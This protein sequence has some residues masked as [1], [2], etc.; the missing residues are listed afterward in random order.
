MFFTTIQAYCLSKAGVEETFPF[1][2]TTVVWKVMG[3]MF[4]V[5]D[6]EEFNVIA[7]KCD[8]ER[9]IKLREEFDQIKPGYHMNKKLW[10]SV[11]LE[12]LSIEMVYELIDHSYDL[13]VAKLTKTLKT[14]LK[15]LEEI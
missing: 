13:V 10:N 6:I 9:S 15:E 3:K 4:C 14:Q 12:G 2:E 1:D 8:P 11:Y 7:L 5:G